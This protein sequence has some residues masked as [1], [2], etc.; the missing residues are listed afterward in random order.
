MEIET[1]YHGLQKFSSKD[2]LKFDSGIPGFPDQREFL[3]LPL[4]ESVLTV[5]QSIR[6]PEI[7]FVVVDPFSF[8]PEYDFQLSESV[9]GQLELEKAEDAAVFTILTVQDPFERTTANL[10]API[11]INSKNNMAKQVILNEGNHKTKHPLFG[12]K[13]KG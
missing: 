5:L 8:F 12:T 11:V 10:Q 4:D 6:T 9:V 2:I 1:K 13:A 3:L 7:G